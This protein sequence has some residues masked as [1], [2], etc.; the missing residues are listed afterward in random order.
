[1]RN[2]IPEVA[3]AVVIEEFYRGSNNPAFVRA[4]LQT[5]PATSKQ[6]FREA[7]IYI[8]ANEQA[9]DLIGGTKPIPPAP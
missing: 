8:T 6:L 5:A 3:E 9:Q 2:H 1:M 4:I 7:D